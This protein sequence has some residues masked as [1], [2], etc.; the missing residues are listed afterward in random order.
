MK[1]FYAYKSSDGMRHEDALEAT[2]REEVFAVLRKRGIKAI[3]VI[4]ADGSKANGAVQGV[5]KRLVAALFASAV[6]GTALILYWV[7]PAADVRPFQIA[8]TRRQVIGDAAIIEQGIR[9]G[10]AEVFSEAGD[11]FL[12]SFAIPGVEAGVRQVKSDEI[13]RAL[14]KNIKITPTDTL[15]AQQIKSMVQG[16]KREARQYL[17][18]GGTLISYGQ[19]LVERQ[20]TELAI[21]RRVEEEVLKAS[22]TLDESAFMSFYEKKNDE[23]RNLGLRPILL[24]SDD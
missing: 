21:A 8:E 10:W 5:R 18:A 19:R 20:E 11:R 4:A 9:S 13:R 3:K 15:E 14:D 24:P 7:R 1:Y 17:A 6:V 22:K 23:L 16:M 2:S 12:A